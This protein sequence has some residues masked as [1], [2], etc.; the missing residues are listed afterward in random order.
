MRNAKMLLGTESIVW[1]AAPQGMRWMLF[2]LCCDFVSSFCSPVLEILSCFPFLEMPQM[3]KELTSSSQSDP[4][5]IAS[6][7][8]MRYKETLLRCNC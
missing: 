8:Q 2:C 4:F 1:G 7:D 3:G 6:R 5:P